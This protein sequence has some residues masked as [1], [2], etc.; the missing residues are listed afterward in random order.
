[1][2][3]GSIPDHRAREMPRGAWSERT[4][5]GSVTLMLA[6]ASP[7]IWRRLIIQ[8]GGKFGAFWPEDFFKAD[9]RMPPFRITSV[10]AH[11]LASDSSL[12][13]AEPRN[14]RLAPVCIRVGS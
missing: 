1:M 11:R 4:F 7:G 5:A 8:H 3:A 9:E 12:P 2:G 10:E 6:S 13:W 14:G